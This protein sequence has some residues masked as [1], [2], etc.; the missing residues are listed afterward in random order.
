MDASEIFSRLNAKDVIFPKEME[1]SFFQSQMHES[2]FLE[3][4]KT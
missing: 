2:I 4:I 1:D 3:E